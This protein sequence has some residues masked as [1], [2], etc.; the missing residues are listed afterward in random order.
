MS[1]RNPGSRRRVEPEE[2][3]LVRR[4]REGDEGAFGRLVALHQHE[5]FTLAL[6]L[7][8]DR[9][10]AADVAQE[11]MIRA[12]KAMPR[13]R[14]EAAF[15][16]WLHRIIVNTAWTQHSRSKRHRAGGLDDV[17]NLPDPV[18]RNDP[19]LAGERIDLR[20]KLSAAL[21]SLPDAQRAVVVLKDVYGW[22]HRE[23]A[24]ALSITVTAA[25]VRLHR[26]HLHLRDRLKEAT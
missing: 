12:W 2:E 21:A 24:E 26:A 6:R 7:V 23:I 3:E 5:V 15:S 8:G 14:G 11:A 4:A 10:L 18:L 9:A 25:K 1:E 19:Q 13:F 17:M 16:T 22:S 20:G